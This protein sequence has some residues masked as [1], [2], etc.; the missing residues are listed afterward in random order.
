MLV[1][2]HEIPIRYALNAAAG[3]DNLDAP[4]HAIPN[5]A[6]FLFDENALAA[7]TAGIE[8]LATGASGTRSRR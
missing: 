7:A 6:P 5:A 4:V 3:S 1:V 2:S 8:Q